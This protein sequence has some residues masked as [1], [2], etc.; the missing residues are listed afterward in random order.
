M[1]G[2]LRNGRLIAKRHD[3]AAVVELSR[4]SRFSGTPVVIDRWGHPHSMHRR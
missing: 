3:P 2:I 1:Y 4:T